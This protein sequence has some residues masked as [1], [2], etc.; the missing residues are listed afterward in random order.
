M[1]RVSL[2]SRRKSRLC[3]SSQSWC[4]IR[5]SVD[6]RAPLTSRFTKRVD[7]LPDSR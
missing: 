4:A 7:L 6:Q 5:G 3:R 2:A 1:Q